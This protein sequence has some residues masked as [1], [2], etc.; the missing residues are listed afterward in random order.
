MPFWKGEQAGRPLEF[1]RAIG[2][3]VRSLQAQPAAV[4]LAR[5][6]KE[7]DLDRQAAENLLQYLAD[8]KAAI[9]HVP[10]DRTIVIERCRD[11]LGDWRVCL[12]SPLG[13]RVMAPWSMAI[14]AGMREDGGIDAETM[15]ND[16]GL[17]VR[18]PDTDEPPDPRLLLPDPDDVEALVLRQLG[19]TSLFAG[20][21]RE[22]AARALLLPRR[23]MGGRTPLW[24]QRKRAADLLAVASKFGSF[25]ML[26]EAY[27]ECLRDLFDVPALIDTLRAIRE[28]RLRDRHRR[29]DD[30]VAV[31]GLA[32]LRL[33]RAVPL[34]RRRAAGRAPRPGALDRSR[35]AQGAARRRR[36]A[37]RA[38]PRRHRRASSTSCST[39]PPSGTCAPSTASTICCCASAT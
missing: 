32:A 22:A 28:R 30:A 2:A 23:R 34:R 11:E 31:R 25:P 13:G 14:L 12:L 17:V 3:L 19:A 38:R 27:R 7:H 6:E 4:A 8:Q 29:L 24:Q 36:A 9:G 16:D 20:K 18:F 1:G 21:F 15:W 37:R 33:R 39:S 26:L 5:L 35:A 10:D